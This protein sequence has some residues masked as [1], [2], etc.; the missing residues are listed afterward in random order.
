MRRARERAHVYHVQF[1]TKGAAVIVYN[2]F[3]ILLL[4]YLFWIVSRRLRLSC[5]GYPERLQKGDLE[6]RPK[7]GERIGHRA[8]FPSNCHAQH[9]RHLLRNVASVETDPPALKG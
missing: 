8:R 1:A 5:A 3:R 6:L 4:F 9:L 7:I 2:G